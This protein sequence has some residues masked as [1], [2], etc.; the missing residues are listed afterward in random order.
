MTCGPILVVSVMLTG[1]WLQSATVAS[2]EGSCSRHGGPEGPEQQVCNSFVINKWTKYIKLIQEARELYNSSCETEGPC[3]GCY[4]NVLRD[5][6]DIWNKRGG[7]T[8][9]EFISAL[10][11]GVHYQIIDQKL[12]RETNCPFPARCR[13]VEHFILGSISDLPNM[14]MVFN[15]YDFPKVTMATSCTLSVGAQ[16][17]VLHVM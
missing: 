11:L 9:E 8:R 14:E 7:I 13:G 1:V 15:V 12:Y 17:L 6:L 4:H 16:L 10:S 2:N 3:G 5:D